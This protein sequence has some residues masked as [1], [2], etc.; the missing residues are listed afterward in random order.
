VGTLGT[1]YSTPGARARVCVHPIN[2]PLRAVVRCGSCGWWRRG[3]SQTRTSIKAIKSKS[4]LIHFALTLSFD[5]DDDSL[6]FDDEPSDF[7][8]LCECFLCSFFSLPDDVTARRD[9]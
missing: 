6:D 4:A 2:H 3:W 8:D 5:D 7:F 9:E 1:S